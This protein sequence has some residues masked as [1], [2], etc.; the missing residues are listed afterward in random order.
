MCICYRN[1]QAN[2]C[3]DRICPFG[4]A[5]VDAP[6][7]DLDSSDSIDNDVVAVNSAQYPYG[8]PEDFPEMIDS[9]LHKLSQTAHYY[10]ECSNAGICNRETGECECFTGFEG[11]SCQRMKCPGED[12]PCSGHGICVTSR[13]AALRN[14]GSSY[15]LWD[16]DTTTT[17]LC[18]IGFYGHDCSMRH[19]PKGIDPM[20][21]DDIRTVQYPF[22][23]F[24]LMTTSP[25][26]NINDGAGGPGY[27]NLIIYDGFG[28]P[29]MTRNIYTPTS[30]LE[31]LS[32][33]EQLP[34]H[35]VR[36][37]ETKCYHNGIHQQNAITS[38]LINVTYAALYRSYFSGTRMYIDHEQP[39]TQEANYVS[40]SMNL[41]SN[42]L[43]T[44]D[45]FL[46]QFYG[47]PGVF[48]QP[49]I[50]L[51]SN[52]K[53]PTMQSND[54]VIVAESWTNGQQGIDYDFFATRC[55]NVQVKLVTFEGK[56]FLWGGFLPSELLKC[57]GVNDFNQT[58]DIE[59]YGYSYDVGTVEFPHI[60]KI[61]RTVSDRRDGSF[62]I[63]FVQETGS[64]FN[65]QS[66]Q[67][68][69]DLPPTNSVFRVLHHAHGLDDNI[70]VLFDVFVNRGSL[71]HRIQNGSRAEFNFG[72]KHIFMTNI[73]S[74]HSAGTVP[75][76][77]EIGC[78]FQFNVQG[79][80]MNT[81]EL[82]CLDNNDYF[83]LIDPY[84]TPNNP[85][86]LNMYRVEGIKRVSFNDIVEMGDYQ[87][88]VTSFNERKKETVLIVTDL[89]TNALATVAG[90]TNFHIY[91][92]IP[93]YQTAYEVHRQCSGR[94]ICNT[95]E[96]LC[97]CFS[98]Y[99]GQA[100]EIQTTI[101]F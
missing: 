6:K 33:I 54:G 95:F 70:D 42:S 23:F 28:Q 60:I 71:L 55:S 59:G 53:R 7:G 5:V 80:G 32:A 100:C 48:K 40:L 24:S 41:T 84:H 8:T 25:T 98:G 92:F 58:N 3:S 1:W 12:E 29:Y 73:S 52:G 77:G 10:T 11:V 21:F 2:D 101:T 22:F 85:P 57:V 90:N 83:F 97:D 63:V 87:Y 68:E 38:P 47:R 62:F 30:C 36:A 67:Y 19:C 34:N 46:L 18:D 56:T 96:G 44:G 78:D 9:D 61:V 89:H 27:F 66:G 26:Y 49:L 86:F 82:N 79:I 75:F 45:L 81:T 76:N 65:G 91:R 16:R 37:G 4:L 31:L 14:G 72:S 15:H 50:N 35:V 17:C 99:T 64:Y 13:K 43:I 51:Y 74:A 69:Y 20:F 39:A 94:G 93:N 88:N